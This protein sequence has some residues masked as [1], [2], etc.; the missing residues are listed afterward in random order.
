MSIDLEKA[1]LN[2]E[3]YGSTEDNVGFTS[4]NVLDLILENIYLCAKIIFVVVSIHSLSMLISDN[5][6][7]ED[8]T[9][10][11]NDNGES[12][13]DY[14]FGC[15]EIY[16]TCHIV[17]TS[18]YSTELLVD[19]RIIHKHNELGSN[20]PRFVDMVEDYRYEHSPVIGNSEDNCKVDLTCD[21][22]SYFGKQLNETNSYI[23][24]AYQRNILHGGIWGD[25]GIKNNV[26]H[27]CPQPYSIIRFYEDMNRRLNGTE[28]Y[29]LSLV[30]FSM[31]VFLGFTCWK[32]T[33]SLV[34]RHP[35]FLG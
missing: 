27:L 12:C 5:F 11:M 2:E 32:V 20:C 14:E 3:E 29:L 4:F 13:E 19:P 26:Y 7:G 24:R 16:D 28:Y 6:D 25:T 8:K 21:Y 15:C 18:Y 35:N 17:N 10:L 34:T 1:P 23:A 30:F 9:F 31:S 22:R 33:P